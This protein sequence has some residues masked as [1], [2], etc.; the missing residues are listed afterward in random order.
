M[1][2]SGDKKEKTCSHLRNFTS[3]FILANNPAGEF[4]VYFSCSIDFLLIRRRLAEL[5]G[6]FNHWRDI[7]FLKVIVNYLCEMKTFVVL[8]NC[9]QMIF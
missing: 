5:L 7:N 1:I 8:L 2:N 3:K 4:L 9:V 6:N